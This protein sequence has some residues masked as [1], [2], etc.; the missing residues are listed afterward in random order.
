MMIHEISVFDFTDYRNFLSSYLKFKK[1]QNKKFS[2]RLWAMKLNLKSPSALTMIL[3]GERQAGAGLTDQFIDYFNFTHSQATYFKSLVKLS[4][5]NGD[6][7]KRIELL[8]TLQNVHPKKELHL[9]ETDTFDAISNWYFFAIR[10]LTQIKG[11]K[12]DYRWISERLGK[13]I[14]PQEA[15]KAI[16]TMVR[17]HLLKRSKEGSL[18]Q[19]QEQV[20][21]TVDISSEALKQFHHEMMTL[22]DQSLRNVPVEKR[23]MTSVTLNI[24]PQKMKKVKELI[25]E[26]RIRFTDLMEENPG[27][28]TYQLNIQF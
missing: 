24:D 26:F 8:K 14:T 22:A 25:R 21:T 12:E 15:K 10:E 5:C 2:L 13:K 1:E 18:E 6:E 11:F 9:L 19:T 23:E 7:R 4:K 28:E 27:K 17:L 16:E 20:T 3:K